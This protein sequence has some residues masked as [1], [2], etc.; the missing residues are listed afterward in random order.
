MESFAAKVRYG[1]APRFDPMMEERGGW[2]SGEERRKDVEM[3]DA[4]IEGLAAAS[5]QSG[6]ND[7]NPFKGQNGEILPSNLDRSFSGFLVRKDAVKYKVN[8][9]KLIARIELL[10]DQLLIGKFVGPKPSPQEMSLWIKYLNQELREEGLTF[11]RN[12]GKGYFLL[13]GEDKDALH[14]AMMLS[15]FRSKWGTCMLQSWIP[16][17]NPDNPSNLAFP[18]WVSLRNMPYEHQDQAIAIAETLGEVIGIDTANEEAKDPRF[19]INLE[20]SKGWAT[21]IVLESEE[22]ILPP[23]TITVDY[24]NLPI[25]CRVC[26]SW[27]H[28]ANECKVIQK[29]PMRHRSRS[30]YHQPRQHQDLHRNAEI[31]Q[32]G[33][34]QVKNRRG[35]R[36]NIFA[37]G[38]D[39]QHT[40]NWFSE[41]RMDDNNHLHATGAAATAAAEQNKQGKQND[42]I[43]GKAIGKQATDTSIGSHKGA[44]V[45]LGQ[46]EVAVATKDPASN[47]VDTLMIEVGMGDQQEVIEPEMGQTEVNLRQHKHSQLPNPGRS[48]GELVSGKGPSTQKRACTLLENPLIESGEEDTLGDLVADEVMNNRCEVGGC[49]KEVEA[50]CELP[51]GGGDKEGP[52]NW[53][54]RQVETNKNITREEG[55]TTCENNM[56]W[57]PIKLAG[58]KRNIEAV[59]SDE[60]TSCDTEGEDEDWEEEE[61]GEG[62]GGFKEGDLDKQEVTV[63]V[64]PENEPLG[65]DVPWESQVGEVGQVAAKEATEGRPTVTAGVE[66]N[67]TER[68]YRQGADLATETEGMETEWNSHHG[69]EGAPSKAKNKLQQGNQLEDVEMNA[70]EGLNTRLVTTHHTSQTHIEVIPETQLHQASRNKNNIYN[71]IMASIGLDSPTSSQDTRGE[72]RGNAPAHD[73]TLHLASTPIRNSAASL[74]ALGKHVLTPRQGRLWEHRSKSPLGGHGK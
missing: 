63:G 9:E 73:P 30:T 42:N 57:S 49:H 8:A 48:E 17:F 72:G 12:V 28:K 3:D 2:I 18:T 5:Q 39:E 6:E 22:G 61:E 71:D 4:V 60:E 44:E 53:D 52:G 70:I 58:Q 66:T 14:N 64:G 10:K 31:D 7:L 21:C 29:K 62:G 32:D 40:N 19:C 20:I 37:N 46:T 26:Y 35:I 51:E 11:C 59:E 56:K 23:Q 25:R 69:S 38:H 24:D 47:M 54:H 36:R 1:F 74:M 27:K 43:A 68:T 45:D 50:A 33:F 65:E 55:Q 15:P 67:W 16:G 41:R 34:Q 13:K